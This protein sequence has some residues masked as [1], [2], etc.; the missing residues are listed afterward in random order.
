[1]KDEMYWVVLRGQIIG[2]HSEKEAEEMIGK[3]MTG[4]M[5]MYPE[6]DWEG[7]PTRIEM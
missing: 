5:E 2:K 1:M 4:E 6:F 7:K 3:D